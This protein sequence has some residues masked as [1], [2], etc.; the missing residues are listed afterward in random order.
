M[1]DLKEVQCC[2]GWARLGPRRGT[3]QEAISQGDRGREPPGPWNEPDACPP[4]PPPPLYPSVLAPRSSGAPGKLQGT[5]NLSFGVWCEPG[6][7][8]APG[9]ILSC[10]PTCPALLT[11]SLPT[12][13]DSDAPSQSHCCPERAREVNPTPDRL[14]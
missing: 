4:P 10:D 7:L 6:S 14:F 8:L 1:K 12:P 13:T 3:R 9:D 2:Q 11:W 5:Y